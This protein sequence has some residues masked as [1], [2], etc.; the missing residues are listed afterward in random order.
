ML[1]RSEI[2]V[3]TASEIAP[4]FS[5]LPYIKK[6]WSTPRQR[7]K[8]NILSLWPYI[9]E[10]RKHV[11][12]C[13]LDFGGNDRGALFTFLLKAKKKY[14]LVDSKIK[15]IHRYIYSNFIHFETHAM[16]NVLR[17][18]KFINT[19]G[20]YGN[21]NLK[22]EIITK[23]KLLKPAKLILK[24][25]HVIFH[26]GTSQPKKEWPLDYWFLL[27]QSLSKLGIKVA[28]SA[29]YNL[30]EQKLL[31]DL[32]QL[33]SSI[34][35]IPVIKNLDFYLAV[36]A[37]SKL[38]ISGDTAPLHFG[39]ALGIDVIGLFGTEDSIM[40]ASTIYPAKNKLLGRPC[41]CLRS[42]AHM[43]TCN[44]NNLCMRGI[45]PEK[46]AHLAKFYLKKARK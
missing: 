7:G 25:H 13:I 16:D 23:K 27:Y 34:F 22:L 42:L 40:K 24:D 44:N 38:I 14:A 2:H 30:R 36:L 1:F 39:R 5:N 31:N 19:L 29:G 33:D 46:V 45:S 6:I 43:D 20:I 28:F 8:F 18:L 11:F 35:I 4:I 9:K 41:T 32:K 21:K 37:Q 15:I 26:I 10:L 12:D 3:L 17:N